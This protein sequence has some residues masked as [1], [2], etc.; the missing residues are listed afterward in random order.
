MLDPV[1]F[2]AYKRH[3]VYFN[4]SNY[5]SIAP[6]VLKIEGFGV[7]KG[8]GETFKCW[9]DLFSYDCKISSVLNIH[10]CRSVMGPL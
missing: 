9:A 1:F 3:F 8:F 4:A 5:F 6:K 7:Y 10:L 2:L